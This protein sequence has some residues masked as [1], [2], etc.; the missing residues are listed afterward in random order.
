MSRS[1]DQLGEVDTVVFACVPEFELV[2]VRTK[3]ERQY[4][5]TPETTGVSLS[6]LRPGQRVRCVVSHVT[7]RVF[8]ATVI[9]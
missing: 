7:T 8:S 9:D 4:A 5:L 3:T 1:D 6:T 2:Y